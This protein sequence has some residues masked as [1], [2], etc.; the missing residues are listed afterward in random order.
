[1]P[2]SN[3]LVL[4]LDNPAN[5][6]IGFDI[7]T[8]YSIDAGDTFQISR[9]SMYGI[10]GFR[11]LIKPKEH[12]PGVLNITTKT[13]TFLNPEPG[14]PGVYIDAILVRVKHLSSGMM[15]FFE[16][17]KDAEE[18]FNE[19]FATQRPVYSNIVGGYGMFGSY[20]YKD[21]IIF[22]EK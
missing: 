7:S 17:L 11:S 21:S 14:E 13:A 18:T 9:D 4:E 5:R 15:M 8:F 12:N 22:L 10:F 6:F 19:P 20:S 2:E 1:M 16:G 3:F